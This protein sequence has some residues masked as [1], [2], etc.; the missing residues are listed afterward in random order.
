MTKQQP[1]RV[2]VT[3][4][5]WMRPKLA[6]DQVRDLDLAHHQNLDAIATRQA[7]DVILWHWV[8]AVFTWSKVAELTQAGEP[9]MAEQLALATR[10]VL[11]YGAT[12]R[13]EF[14]GTADLELARDG[15]SVMQQPP[16]SLGTPSAA[17][18]AR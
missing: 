18:T 5:R 15:V 11:H 9:E 14:T 3:L 2:A 4:P 16:V 7:D 6:R 10:M 12:G 13:V 8:E 1:Y 17:W